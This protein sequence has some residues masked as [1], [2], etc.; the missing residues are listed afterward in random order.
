MTICPGWYSNCFERRIG[1]ALSKEKTGKVWRNV[2]S[3]LM[4]FT[5]EA[6]TSGVASTEIG[7]RATNLGRPKCLILGE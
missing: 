4:P 6:S 2:S 5:L 7:G 3:T 1:K